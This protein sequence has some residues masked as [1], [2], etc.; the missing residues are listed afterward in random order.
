MLKRGLFLLPLIAL[1]IGTAFAQAPENARASFVKLGEIGVSPGTQSSRVDLSAVQGRTSA[2]QLRM[3][4]GSLTLSRISVEYS[5]GQ[6]FVDDAERRLALKDRTKLIDERPEGRFVDA[7]EVGYPDGTPPAQPTVLEVWGRQTGD[8][9]TAVRGAVLAPPDEDISLVG[10]ATLSLSLDRDVVTLDPPADVGGR[11]KLRA[12]DRDI[13]I[14]SAVVVAASG[15]AQTV[16]INAD[17]AAGETSPWISVD[18]D[19]IR[20]IRLNYRPQPARGGAA[21]IAIYGDVPPVKTRSPEEAAKEEPY[22]AVPVYYGTDR[23]RGPDLVK[24]GRKLAVYTN[25]GG[26]GLQLGMAVVTIPTRKDRDPGV[27]TRPDWNLFFTTIAFRNED[28]ARDFTVQSVDELGEDAFV[29]KARERIQGAKDFKDQAF[30]FVHG[31]NVVFDDALFRTA[32]IAHDTGF[33]GGAFLYSWPSSGKLIGYTH[34]LK[35]VDGARDHLMTFLNV[36]RAK[37]GATKVH[38][39]AHSMGAEL[40]TGVLR[41]IALTTSAGAPAALF[42]EII[43]A[44]PDVTRDNFLKRYKAITPLG[45][46]VTLYASEKDR[47][48]RISGRVALGERPIGHIPRAGAPVIVAGIDTIDVSAVSSDFFS[49]N[50]SEFAD[51]APLLEDIARIIKTGLRPPKARYAPFEEIAGRSG[52]YWKHPR[53]R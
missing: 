22:I 25:A 29:Q 12:V 34:D 44:S 17:L 43:L 8:D 3:A 31:Y 47:A 18:G 30:V 28:M 5:N 42:E 6:V 37:T 24:G 38:L 10:E 1:T 20:E 45:R 15:A 46:G 41:D 51:R 9:A 14:V 2:V 53:P 52:T 39:I 49:L 40:L 35:R 7:V 26:S 16:D 48:L 32:Q 23:Q 19:G 50:H 11:I 21:A 36:I 27:I 33:D 13:W 4:Q